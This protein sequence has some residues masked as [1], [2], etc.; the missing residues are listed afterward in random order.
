MTDTDNLVRSLERAVATYDHPRTTELCNQLIEQ[1]RSTE[2]PFP[3]LAAKRVLSALRRKR[4]FH[5][6]AGVADALLTSGRNDMV[7]YRQ[8]AQALLD[9]GLTG[10]ALDMLAARVSAADD[11]ADKAELR[12]LVGRAHKDRYIAT[13]AAAHRLIHLEA[14]VATYH[15]AWREDPT[16]LWHGIN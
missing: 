1:L 2:E 6:M 11:P 4:Q 15:E 13:A 3:A 14:A 12:G 9:L 16:R 10:A 5:L 7:T 8:Y